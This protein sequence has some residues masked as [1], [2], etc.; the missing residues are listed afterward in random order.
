MLQKIFEKLDSNHNLTRDDLRYL[1][2]LQDKEKI[3]ALYD[4]AYLEKVKHTGKKVFLRGLIELSNICVKDC[5]YCGIR[6][7][8][9]TID[10]FSL[11][12]EEII[13]GAE[14]AYKNEYGSMVLQAGERYD[15]K[16]AGFIEDIVQKIKAKT[17]DRLG[18]TL[19]LGEQSLETYK[20]WFNAGAH[21]YLLR[22]ETSNPELYKKLHPEDHSFEERKA[23]LARLREA[24]FQVGTGVM[25]G[26]PFQTYEDLVDDILFFKEIDTDMIGMGPYLISKETPLAQIAEKNMIIAEDKL[27]LSLKMIAVTRLFL[28]DVN[29]A[30]TT[31]L[32]AIEEEGREKGLKAGANIIMPNVTDVQYRPSY[33][34]Y[35]NKPCLDENADVCRGCLELR[36]LSIDEE[37]GYGEWGDSKHFS[38]RNKA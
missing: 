23:A 3:Q 37:I 12:E 18:I 25:I 8:N 7:S 35:D 14:W 29:I 16:F 20:R 36:I 24:G 30:A 10:R 15:E 4:R 22:I 27:Q 33:Q 19:S 31:A 32:Q 6:K 9:Y 11:T 21:R 13:S 28:G 26:L 17:Q 1:L 2:T 5:Y 34:L 38:K